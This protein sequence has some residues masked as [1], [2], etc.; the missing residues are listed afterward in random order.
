MTTTK[1]ESKL[2]TN[3][4][5]L[6]LMGHMGVHNIKVDLVF[7]TFNGILLIFKPPKIKEDIDIDY[8]KLRHLSTQ[9]TN[10]AQKKSK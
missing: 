7:Q 6:N 4:I 1:V 5:P 9:T 3:Q 10:M 8:Q 2:V